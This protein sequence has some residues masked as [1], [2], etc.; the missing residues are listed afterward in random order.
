MGRRN[1]V[2]RVIL[3]NTALFLIATLIF[4][5][6]VTA[7][8]WSVTRFKMNDMLISN[9]I[10]IREYRERFEGEM[11][12]LG[13]NETEYAWYLTYKQLN[14]R[15]TFTGTLEYYART[16][17]SIF[18]KVEYGPVF[19]SFGHPIWYYLKNTVIILIMVELT[20]LGLGTYLGLKAGY[21]G[22]RLDAL[23]SALAQLFSAVPVWFIGALI[24]LLA[25]RF[26]VVPDFTMRVQL[27]VTGTIG[28]ASAYIV[29]FLLPAITMGIASIW[30][31]AY[32][33][34]NIVATEKGKRLRHLRQGQGAP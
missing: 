19:G 1:Q 33:L 11:E 6:L 22:G 28:K 27:T 18:G 4:L 23:V 5:T 10:F 2:G 21:N 34:R 14:I 15:P 31:Y 20:V 13:M 26:S 30:E 25:W 24:F 7:A 8:Q 29:G 32:T 3:K 16:A 17:F 12:K 9:L